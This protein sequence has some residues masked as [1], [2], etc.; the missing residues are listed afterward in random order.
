MSTL[1]TRLKCH[2]THHPRAPGPLPLRIENSVRAPALL[3]KLRPDSI[4]RERDLAAWASCLSARDC[5]SRYFDI[6]RRFEYFELQPKSFTP[7][8]RR[9]VTQCTPTRCLFAEPER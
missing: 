1:F 9:L 2:D 7:W 6:C 8:T 5:A 3:P 4:R